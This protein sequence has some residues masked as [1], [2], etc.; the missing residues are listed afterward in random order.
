MVSKHKKLHVYLFRRVVVVDAKQALASACVGYYV[1]RCRTV[2]PLKV[3]SND[4]LK[5]QIFD[6]H[7]CAFA[8]LLLYFTTWSTYA[9]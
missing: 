5:T 6:I 4:K 7:Y 2:Q 9:Q 1:V 8:V 3:H